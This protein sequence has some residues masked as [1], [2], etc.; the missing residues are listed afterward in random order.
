[1]LALSSFLLWNQWIWGCGAK[2]GATS[3]TMTAHSSSPSPY[4]NLHF[5]LG[6]ETFSEAYGEDS[7]DPKAWVDQESVASWNRKMR[8]SLWRWDRMVVFSPSVVGTVSTLW[9]PQ[10]LHRQPCPPKLVICGH[11]K[12]HI[13][14]RDL[15][16]PLQLFVVEEQ[17]FGLDS[18]LE[19]TQTSPTVM[20]GARGMQRQPPN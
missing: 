11:V 8:L 15:T 2:G 6:L 4:L 12:S 18:C 14:Q 9:S 7:V 1:M 10:A 16:A 17:V 19:A 5:F 3:S 20:S 13:L